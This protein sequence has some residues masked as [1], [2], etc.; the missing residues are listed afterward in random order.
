MKKPENRDARTSLTV[1]RSCAI[2][3]SRDTRPSLAV[4]RAFAVLGSRDTRPSLAVAI[5]NQAEALHQGCTRCRACVSHCAFLQKNGTPG[6]IA[7]S[8]LAG[9]SAVDPFE[10]SLCNLCTGVC[11]AQI[12]PGDF[13]LE[14]RRQVVAHNKL[15]VRRYGPILKYEK[16]GSS[17][18][19]SWYGLPTGCDTVFFPGCT[20]PGTRPETTWS[21][22]Q[23]LQEQIPHL[24]AVLDCC[25]KPSHDLGRQDSFLVWFTDMRDWLIRHGV[26][27]I[28][29][30]CPNCYKIFHEY[31]HGLHVRTAWEIFAEIKVATF[32]PAISHSRV[33]VHDPCP[34]RDHQ[35]A[36][37]AVRTILRR[38]GLK[39]REMRHSRKHTICCGEGGSVGLINPDLAGKW[40]EKRKMEAGNDLVITYCAGCAALLA[41]T[42]IK[43]VHLGD[44]LANPEKALTGKASVARAPRTY[45]NRIRLKRRLQKAIHTGQQ[46]DERE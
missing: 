10:C 3:G 17:R 22:Y 26:R 27:L 41:K 40:G 4:G 1:G 18:L 19:F 25:H 36:Q 23:Q 20:L 37:Q 16:R 7:A 21:I 12:A 13:F 32:H 39:V 5:H 38:L 31:G 9:N 34:L 30:A 6:E 42:G 14:M 46:N 44:L 15:P 45:L 8:L 33:T 29:V 43:V 35:D 24:G 11:P 28:I 2:L